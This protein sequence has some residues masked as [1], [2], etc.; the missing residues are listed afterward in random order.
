MLAA[1]EQL[2]DANTVSLRTQVHDGTGR[3][4]MVNHCSNPQCA[5]PLHYLRDGRIF[6]FDV[7]VQN[8]GGEGKRTRRIE[9]Y[10]LCG[11]CLQTMLLEQSSEGVRLIP[12]PATGFRSEVAAS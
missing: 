12:R 7:P 3:T 4:F 1:P 6:V 8:L 2:T 11:A 10:W 9:H 5:K